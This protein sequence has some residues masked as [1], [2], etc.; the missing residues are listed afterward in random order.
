M[1]KIRVLIADDHALV[2]EG[3]C[4]IL[5]MEKSI[6]V[7]GEAENGEQA[8]KLALKIIPDIIL[9]DINMPK[10]KGIEATRIIKSRL[11]EV[12]IIALTIHDQEEYLF[13]LIKAGISGY[14]LK[15]ISPDLLIQTILGVTRGESFIPPS[16]TAKVFAEFTRLSTI[17]SRY[18]HPLGLT[19][20]EVDVLRLVAQGDSNRSIAQKLFISEKTVKNHLTSIFQKLGVDDR[21]QAALHAVK[22]KIIEL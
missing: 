16:M 14:V 3:L 20:R 11:P 1:K 9:M 19:R 5:S 6:E 17:S 8:I 18:S 10:T 7:V 2:R 22:N 15:D 4:K 13:E 21:T 12:G